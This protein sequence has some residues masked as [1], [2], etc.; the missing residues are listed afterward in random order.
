MA[1]LA[2]LAAIAALILAISAIN[3]INRLTTHI[4]TREVAISPTPPFVASPAEHVSETPAAPAALLDDIETSSTEAISEQSLSPSLEER[5]GTRWVV[6]IGGLT[7]MLGGLFLVRYSIEQDLIG[8]GTRVLLGALFACTLLVAGEW[9]RRQESVSAIHMLPIANIPALLTA[10]GTVVAFGTTYASYALYEFLSAAAAFILLGIVGIGALAAALLHGPALAGLGV[11]AAFVT[12]VLVSSKQP[13]YWSLYVYLAVV[14][15]ISFALARLRMWRWLAITTIAFGLIWTIP[16]LQCGPSMVAPHLFHVVAGFSLAAIFVVSGLLFGPHQESRRVEAVSS[17]SLAAYLFASTI[18]VIMSYHADAALTAFV[19]L[20][21]ATLAIAW[22]AESATAAVA[23]AAILVSLV[24]LQWIVRIFPEIL[25]IPGGPLLGIGPNTGDESVSLHLVTALIF[26]AGFGFTGFRAQGRSQNAIVPVIWSA[27]ATFTPVAL[28][29]ALYARI[30]HFDRSVPCAI[31]ATLV[32]GIFAVAT[33]A[34]MKREHQRGLL[35]STAL[36][37]TGTLASLALALTFALEKGWLTIAL[38]LMC[39]GTAWISMQR[40]VPFLRWLTAILSIIVMLRIGYEPRIV[41]NEIGTTFIFN[42]LLWGYGAPALSFWAASYFLRKR[43]DDTPLRFVE[44]AAIVFI[45]LLAFMEIRHSLNEGH[46]YTANIG[47]TEVALQVCTALAI[48]IGLERLQLRS[49][50]FIHNVGSILIT[51]LAGLDIVFGLLILKWPVIT[52][53]NVGGMVFNL[54]FLSY[55]IPAGLAL[56][57]SYM[58]AASSRPPAYSNTI[59]G[60]ALI[61]ALAYVSLEVRRFYHG[62]VLTGTIID[63]EQY[64]YSVVW[65]VFGV[66]LLA[67]GIVFASQRAR[68]ASAGVIG[69]TVLKVFLIDMSVLTGFYRA[70]SFIGLGLVLMSIGWLY[71]RILFRQPAHA[72]ATTRPLAG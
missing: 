1:F 17:G 15:G 5:L 37:A 40:A 36:F 53:A 25:V 7:L 13:D 22:F 70:L 47:L 51:I 65:L 50:S 24:F 59:A 57:L 27:A 52:G 26:A 31:V 42:W 66:I 28:L 49:G 19:M 20:V 45:V 33:E 68:L 69:V 29:I 23:A 63:A 67:A 34:L 56:I 60:S 10:A 64:S 21:A 30:A 54:L 12:P 9:T 14:T 55:A 48:A 39:A 35:I 62:P 6:W 43:G 72:T 16:C 46:I 32:G 61:L 41:G 71:Q 2:L 3:R 44:T 38:A 11:A 58:T 4:A 8:P 18:I